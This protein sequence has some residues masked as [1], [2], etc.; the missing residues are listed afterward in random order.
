MEN[1]NIDFLNDDKNPQNNLKK[2]QNDFLNKNLFLNDVLYFK[3][4]ILKEIKELDLKINIQ[5]NINNEMDRKLLSYNSKLED[6]NKKIDNFSTIIN[7]KSGETNYYAEK[8]DALFEFKSKIEQDSIS[9]NCKLKLTAEE[10]KDAINKYDRLIKNNIIYPGIIGIDS[11]FKDYHEFIDYVLQQLQNFTLFK[12]KNIFDLKSY[13]KKLESNMK[14]L[15]IQ[16]QSLLNNANNYTIKNI[17]DMEAK[18]LNEIKSFDEKLTDLR[19]ENCDFVKKIEK[20]NKEIVNEWNNILNLKKDITELVET[21]VE[22]I[23]NSNYNIQKIINDYQEQINEIKNN[24]IIL[25]DIIQG[26][27]KKNLKKKKS[28]LKSTQK[29]IINDNKEIKEVNNISKININKVDNNNNELFNKKDEII[30]IKKT[31]IMN[32]FKR[33]KSAES[34]IKNYI[35][36]KSTLEELT[37]KRNK[38]KIKE[39]KNNIYPISIVSLVSFKKISLNNNNNRNNCNYKTIDNRIP[40]QN[41]SFY[42]N[43]INKSM[44]NSPKTINS[45]ERKKIAFNLDDKLIDNN[46]KNNKQICNDRIHNSEGKKKLLIKDGENAC[47][48]NNKK[49]SN[50]NEFKNS[51]INKNNENYIWAH[52]INNIK[53]LNDISFLVEN[54]KVDYIFPKIEESKIKQIEINE[55]IDKNKT[56]NNKINNFNNKNEENKIKKISDEINKKNDNKKL[57]INYSTNNIKSIQIDYSIINENMAY[58]KQKLKDKNKK[59]VNK[60]NLILKGN[61][62]DITKFK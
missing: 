45:S 22:K 58:S 31:I 30:P 7:K 42:Q 53:Q 44:N 8:L 23:K 17:K 15:N 49:K 27:K 4:D 10:L 6:L 5:N 12:E 47:L 14:S 16:I 51:L 19:V 41:V 11:K 46:S 2:K 54:K 38:K 61:S 43:K 40:N 55:L 35:Q 20:Q 32:K 56:R 33:V 60:F 9:Q 34:I 13:K 21:T 3:N 50:E 26:N 59:K 39:N 37:E 52:K 62:I 24:Y 29:E 28:L 57:S 18:F 48:Y 36:G 1:K 25:L